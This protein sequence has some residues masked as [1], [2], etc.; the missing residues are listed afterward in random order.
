MSSSTCSPQP[1]ACSP[2]LWVKICGM[3]TEEGIA[4]AVDA[5]VQAVG[6]VFHRASKRWIEPARAAELARGVPVGILKV[7]VTLHPVQADVD[8]VLK[9]FRP[10]AWQTDWQ[11]LA[12]LSLPAG[13]PILPVVRSGKALP[14]PLPGRILF[15]GPVS[16]TGET[17]DWSAALPLA[18]RCEL[19]L[20]GGLK[21][22]N[23]EQ[24]VRQVRPFGVDVSSGV[25]RTPGIKDPGLI[26]EFVRRAR[27][28][29]RS[30]EELS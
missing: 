29:V 10:D 16:G 23:V 12:A 17:A 27:T 30:G 3:T 28:A 5:G 8:A 2:G 26:R 20:A 13:L 1:A 25:E 7:A 19:I 18:G 15:E 21:A 6:F 22:A 4:A 24:A 11:D 9:D 14:E